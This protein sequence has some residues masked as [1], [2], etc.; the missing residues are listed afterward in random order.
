MSKQQE[1]ELPIVLFVSGAEEV[2]IPNVWSIDIDA[3]T[4][5]VGASNR[6]R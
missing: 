4:R 3:D 6:H 5:S 1:V 2:V